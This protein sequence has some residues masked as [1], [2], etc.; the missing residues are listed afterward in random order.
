MT[1]P[2]N[3]ENTV[4][5]IDEIAERLAKWGSAPGKGK[6][7]IELRKLCGHY[8]TVPTAY[9]LEGVEKEGDCPRYQSNVTEIWKGRYRGQSVALKIL[10]VSQ[11]NPEIPRTK[12]RFCKEVVLMKQANH[13][14]ILPFYGV[15]TTV[16]DFCLVFPWYKNGNI[17]KYLEGNP[18]VNRFDLL[19]DA[20]SGLS[21]LHGK[22][23]VHGALLPSH[24][25]V[26]DKGNARLATAGRSSI[27]PV[28]D[29]SMAGYNPSEFVGDNN[30]D[31][32]RYSAPE[33]QSPEDFGMDKI[34]FTEGS[35]VY[36]MAMV[37]YEVL[38]GERPYN[39]YK[40][41][42]LLAKVQAG[43]NP[44]RPPAGVIPDPV[45]EHLEKCWRR[46]PRERPSSVEAYTT[47]AILSSRVSQYTVVP[48]YTVAPQNVQVSRGQRT[49]ELPGKLK[50]QFLSLKLS[51]PD[52][53]RS[54]QI[55]VKAKYGKRNHTT[56]PL[57]SS[58]EHKWNGMEKWEIETN[59]Q[60]SQHV[61]LEVFLRAGRFPFQKDK[62]CAVGDLPL[63]YNINSTASA[64]LKPASG[65]ITSATVRI[66]LDEM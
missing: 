7:I 10:R 44:A 6:V 61:F 1:E 27:V 32:Y 8:H 54:H 29:S 59:G 45:W 40:G 36:G 56:K 63:L 9:K 62:V 16:S 49:G 13:A 33:V 22:R 31:E 28:P 23:L 3:F 55:Y 35:D 51:P 57:D 43:E 65:S 47:L 2:S 42:L 39:S 38:T 20:A 37:T 15:S 58:G 52:Q 66:R 17:M 11:D 18:K 24:V 12:S 25:L 4:K 21:F 46:T 19:S 30:N 50:L 14:N 5:R 34:L 53:P 48:Q 26:D 60:D 41:H 64:E